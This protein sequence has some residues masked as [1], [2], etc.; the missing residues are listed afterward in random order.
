MSAKSKIKI[1]PPTLN[2]EGRDTPKE[3]GEFQTYKVKMRAYLKC[4]GL[5]DFIEGNIPKPVPPT[6]IK[7]TR[8]KIIRLAALPNPNPW[9]RAI[10]A[11]QKWIKFEKDK[12]ANVSQR[13]SNFT[14]FFQH[15]HNIIMHVRRPNVFKAG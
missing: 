8:Q 13:S 15:H 10:Q 11:A 3:I 14:Q 5:Q 4:V 9:R 6:E 7:P 2:V 12:R 1:D